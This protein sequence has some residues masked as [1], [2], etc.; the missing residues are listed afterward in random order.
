MNNRILF[1]SVIC[2]IAFIGCKKHSSNNSITCIDGVNIHETDSLSSIFK[3]FEIIRLETIDESLIG[4]RINKIRK[5]NHTYFISYD[6]KT[7]VIFNR[8]GEFLRKIQKIG[9]GPG[10]YTSLVDFD[11]LPNGNII[12]L[13][14]RKLLLY[15]ND[16]EFLKAIPLAIT[17]FNFKIIDDDHFLICA[18]GEKYSIYLINE[19]G[20]ILSKQIATNN[21]PVLGKSVA[22]FALGKNHI[23]YQQDVS[24]D[25]LSFNTKTNKFINVNL[26]CNDGYNLSIQ[27]VNKYK[28][29]EAVPNSWNY[30]KNNPD[31]KTINGFSSYADYLFFAYGN[32]NSGF[33]CCFMNTANNAIDYVLTENT[34]NDISFTET[35]SLIGKT[36]MSDSEDCFISCVYPYQII[37]GLNKNVKL[38]EHP[39]YQHLHSL[40]KNIQ[41]IENENPV[42]IELRISK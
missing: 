27:T 25:F 22:F 40:F 28:E 39:N 3:N 5:K 29:R 26:L 13:D 18:S 21:R 30:L 1:L 14:V 32:Q 20:D 34:V 7:L 9:P 35:F 41:D 17:C 16:G 38:N 19:N 36:A 37:D 31:L 12:I 42:L 10:E 33:K 6:N 24:N 2:F 23:L 15:S 4:Q 11:V 8:Q